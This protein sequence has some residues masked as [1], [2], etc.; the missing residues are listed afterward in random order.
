MAEITTVAAIQISDPLGHIKRHILA[1]RAKSQD[2]MNICM[3]G[4][5]I[6]LAERYTSVAKMLFLTLWYCSIYPASLFICAFALQI[7]FFMD[8]FSL[9]RTWKRSPRLGSRISRF[10]RAYFLPLSIVG[11]YGLPSYRY[12]PELRSL[13]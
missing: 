8:K 3:Q 6:E 11:K 1:P 5:Q 9:T 7:I 13:M 12:L 2:E 10:N 4:T